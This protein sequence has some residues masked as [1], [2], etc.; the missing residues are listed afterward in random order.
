MKNT[1]LCIYDRDA[2]YLERLSRYLMGQRDSP[3][4]IRTYFGD[5]LGFLQDIKEGFLLISSSLLRE[6][7]KT[8]K[9]NRVIVLDEGDTSTEYEEFLHVDKYQPAAVLYELLIGHCADRE[10][11]ISFEG[12]GRRAELYC[13]YSPIR[14]IGKT[15]FCRKLCAEY[16]EKGHVLLLSFEE[17]SKEDGGQ[18]LS[19]LIYFYK[20]GKKHISGELERLAVSDSG[21]GRLAAAAC[22]SDLWDISKEEMKDFL[23]QILDCGVYDSVVLDLNMLMWLPDIFEMAKIIY[24]PYID[25]RCEMNRMR[26]F[27]NMLGL[28]AESGIEGKIQK[29]KMVLS[30]KIGGI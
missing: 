22:P 20:A 14:R 30:E 23:G 21:Y 9:S 17:F 4:L 28:F 16:A 8:L 19:E 18:G 1:P 6:E 24:V 29:V 27:E 15:Q 5:N 25:S 3:F 2:V 26:Q 13:V 10:D 12:D 11:V 7:I